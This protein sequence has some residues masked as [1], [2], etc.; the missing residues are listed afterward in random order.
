MSFLAS[1][2]E[3]GVGGKRQMLLEAN[4]V[5]PLV[6]VNMVLV[7]G[8]SL[9]PAPLEGVSSVQVNNLSGFNIR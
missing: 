7:Q 9:V 3:R 8:V 1:R 5:S 2:G 6:E 4:T